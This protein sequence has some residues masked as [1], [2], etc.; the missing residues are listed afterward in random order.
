MPVKDPKQ[1]TLILAKVNIDM[2]ID[3]ARRFN[4]RAVPTLLLLKSG[5]EVTRLTAGSY[6]LDQ[7][8]EALGTY[9]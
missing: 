5:Q 7:L 1:F 8:H 6:T 9:L 4:V 3:I 2:N